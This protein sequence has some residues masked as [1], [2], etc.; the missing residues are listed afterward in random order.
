[1][2]DG[3][4]NLGATAKLLMSSSTGYAELQRMIWQASLTGIRFNGRA[5][6]A[7]ASYQM[8]IGASWC[9]S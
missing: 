6:N 1:M 8:R 2:N 5:R 9:A 4:G 7:L 3:S